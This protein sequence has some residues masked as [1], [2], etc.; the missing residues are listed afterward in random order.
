V[1]RYFKRGTKKKNKKQTN[2]KTKK[3]KNKKNT[4]RTIEK[5]GTIK[6]ILI[7]SKK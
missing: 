1:P 6:N 5:E 2:K 7:A 3:Q 4:L